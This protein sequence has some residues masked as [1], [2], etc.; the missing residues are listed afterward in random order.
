[1]ENVIIFGGMN[2]F[3]LQVIGATP[4]K[5]IL[6]VTRNSQGAITGFTETFD[7]GIAWVGSET[8]AISL[9][10]EL[11]GFVGTHPVKKPK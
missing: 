4:P 2:N 8:E 5:Y 9:S 10:V 6:E 1:M 3:I 11:S 7:S